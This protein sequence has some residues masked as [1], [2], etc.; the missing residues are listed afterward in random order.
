M[1]S[2]RGVCGRDV[3]ALIAPALGGARFGRIPLCLVRSGANAGLRGNAARLR[4]RRRE[5]A[6][7]CYNPV[8]MMPPPV[9]AY[10]INAL[11]HTPATLSALLANLP[12]GDAAWDARPDP[13][14]FSLREIVAHVADWEAV[15]KERF[16]RAVT[17]ELPLL[18]RPDVGQRAEER[19]YAAADPVT[20]LARFQQE[21]ATLMSRLR[22]LPA[23]A[24]GREAHLERMGDLPLEGLVALTLAHDAYHV[25]QVSEWLGL[26]P[27]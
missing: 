5:R 24:W 12:P 1:W 16:E 8:I 6:V 13:E 19:G 9:R 7:P 3:S 4:G 25:R 15:W 14:R 10:L 18:P 21:R 27:D 23:G 22:S 11:D 26:T 20:S 2:I 17:E